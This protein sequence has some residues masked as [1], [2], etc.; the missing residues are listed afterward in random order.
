M[1]LI[2]L[3]ISELLISAVGV[4]F[5]ISGVVTEG[6]SMRGILCPIAAFT[7]TTSGEFVFLKF[8]YH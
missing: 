6:A 8:F 5:D 3:I 2:N 7:H 4:P 1:V